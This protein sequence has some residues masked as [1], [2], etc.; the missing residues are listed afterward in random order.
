VSSVADA[1]RTG[2][3]YTAYTP[4]TVEHVIRENHLV[5]T[6]EVALQ[7]GISHGSADHIM[8]DVLQYH[9]V[10]AR[11]VPRQL[12]SELKEQHMNACKEHLG[13]CQ[14]EGDVCL[15]CIVT[16]DESW[17]HYFHPETE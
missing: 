12:T 17:A 8:H 11:W 6:V 9:K 16:G 10:C 5:T 4:E 3:P 15:Q 2:C 14:T 7:L 13:H 1:E